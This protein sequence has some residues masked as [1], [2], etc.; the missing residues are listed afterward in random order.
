MCQDRSIWTPPGRCTYFVN[1]R[2]LTTRSSERRGGFRAE[3]LA[4]SPAVAELES[5]RLLRAMKLAT[6]TLV[7]F[8][9]VTGAAFAA[10]NDSGDYSKLILGRWLGPRKFSVFHADGHWGVLR[11][12][13]SSEDIRGRRWHIKGN[14]LILTYPGDHGMDTGT[15]TIVTLT[16][17]KLVT[18]ADGDREEYRRSP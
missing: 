16:A 17:E 13:E 3:F 2:R 11:N 5:V 1:S 10:P 15:Y 12:E 14:K 4:F 9:L 6:A 7:L 8:L 18:D